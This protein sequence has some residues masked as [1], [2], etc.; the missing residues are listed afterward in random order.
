[1]ITPESPPD[2]GPRCVSLVV[3]ERGIGVMTMADADGTNAMSERFVRDLLAALGRAA[4]DPTLRVLV[5]AGTRD[6]FSSGASL[7]M[8]RALARG[9]VLPTDIV[10][11]KAVLDLPVPVIAAM[12]GHAVGGGLALGLA[13]DIVI[14]ARESRYGASF[15]NM[16]FTPG[17]GMTRLLEHVVSPAIAAELL[18]SGELRK[19]AWFEGRSGFNAVLPRADVMP[20]ALEVA[21]RVADKPRA[22]LEMLKRTLSI[23][24]RRTFEETHTLESLMHRVSFSAPDLLARI[25]DYHDQ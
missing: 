3:D 18:F 15:M 8:L 5:L 22:A 9:E 12:E 13:A 17:M 1:M 25:E 23:G 16:G 4:L 19:G 24:R 11:A 21:A 7:E 6:V 20:R 10:L 2:P 14:I